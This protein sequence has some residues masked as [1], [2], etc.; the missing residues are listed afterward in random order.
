MTKLIV[1]K[2][3]VALLDTGL[4]PS[5]GRCEQPSGSWVEFPPQVL[6]GVHFTDIALSALV[7]PPVLYW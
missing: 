6:Y 1:H 5:E 3:H 4:I 2:L 7:S